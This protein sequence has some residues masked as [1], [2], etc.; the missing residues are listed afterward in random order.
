M[1]LPF[2][3]AVI[4]DNIIYLSGQIGNEP[5]QMNVVAGGIGPET[6]QAMKNIQS[7]L[8]ANNASLEDIIKCTIMLEDIS[9]WAAFNKEYVT[10]FPGKKPARSAFGT[11]GLALGAK[12]E[13]ECM[14]CRKC[15]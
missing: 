6:K 4:I 11:N 7:V 14:A 1:N 10:F 3:E 8:Q 15:R 2:S 13:I 5:G 9:E 12:V